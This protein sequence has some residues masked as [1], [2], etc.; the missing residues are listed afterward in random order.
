MK[1][2]APLTLT[3]R[4]LKGSLLG[5]RQNEEM[6]D[7]IHPHPKRRGQKIS[8][9]AAILFA[10]ALVDT[11]YGMNFDLTMARANGADPSKAGARLRPTSGASERSVCP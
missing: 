3:I 10:T 1:S 9:W 11:I 7:R 4:Y 2:D 6:R 5:Q 8:A